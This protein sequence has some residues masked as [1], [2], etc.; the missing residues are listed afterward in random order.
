[1]GDLHPHIQHRSAG[2]GGSNTQSMGLLVLGLSHGDIP[3]SWG[4]P[5]P[6]PSI[7]HSPK[8]TWPGPNGPCP[9]AGGGDAQHPPQDQTLWPRA[10][11]ILAGGRAGPQPY[12]E[13]SAT[14]GGQLS[15]GCH[16]TVHGS[17]GLSPPLVL[18]PKQ[19]AGGI[20]VA[21]WGHSV[22]SVP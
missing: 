13:P 1:M 14:R 8:S 12:K 22:M 16:I 10:I 7:S 5:D 9:C 15:P 6:P 3:M 19:G 2:P 11:Y 18:H 4:P 17:R 21:S 20:P